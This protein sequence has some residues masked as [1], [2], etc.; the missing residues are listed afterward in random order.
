MYQM[1][2]GQEFNLDIANRAAQIVSGMTFR[3]AAEWCA[4]LPKKTAGQPALLQ[5]IEDSFVKHFRSQFLYNSVH[6]ASA[7]SIELGRDMPDA[8]RRLLNTFRPGADK[9]GIDGLLRKNAAVCAKLLELRGAESHPV[10]RFYAEATA[11]LTE[12][13]FSGLAKPLRLFSRA[14]SQAAA[15]FTP[16]ASLRPSER[17]SGP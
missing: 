8:T 5:S 16:A 2:L 10:I 13:D 12:E 14:C 9:E 7:A 6:D 11:A 17:K 1:G 3:Q 4:D 15:S